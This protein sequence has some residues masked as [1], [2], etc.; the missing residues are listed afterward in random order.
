MGSEAIENYRND[1]L[2]HCLSPSAGPTVVPHEDSL[3]WGDRK[4]TD[5]HI[6]FIQLKVEK[7]G[8]ET[9]AQIGR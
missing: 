4:A 2:F 7:T 8:S 1:P 9:W 5:T 6:L 3:G